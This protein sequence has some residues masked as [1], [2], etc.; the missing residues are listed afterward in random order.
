MSLMRRLTTGGDRTSA[1][2]N[3]NREDTV[4]DT[5][6]DQAKDLSLAK[7]DMNTKLGFESFASG[8]L[9]TINPPEFWDLITKKSSQ[10]DDT[11]EWLKRLEV[12]AGID[13][14]QTY[15]R[16]KLAITDRSAPCPEARPRDCTYS[17][18]YTH[19]N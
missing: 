16:T 6:G 17:T 15:E 1:W 7:K 2:V 9:T 4:D 11:L 18:Q 10:P 12:G 3:A 5:L 13:I 8:P 14:V 19:F